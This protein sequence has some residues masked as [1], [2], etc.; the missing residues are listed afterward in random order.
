MAKKA[1]KKPSGSRRPKTAA[2]RRAAT[3]KGQPTAAKSKSSGKAGKRGAPGRKSSQ[4]AADAISGLLESP[5]VADVL[6]AGAAAAMASF[7]HHSLSRNAEGGSK[8]AL[9]DA[10]KAAAAA[11][12]ARLS[13]EF[14]EVM[15]SAN[16]KPK[17]GQA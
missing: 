7:T 12:G 5:L 6:A 10:A 3:S 15:K 4:S 2:S 14:D 13:T 1:T 16:K 11:M 8:Q 17:S 9:K